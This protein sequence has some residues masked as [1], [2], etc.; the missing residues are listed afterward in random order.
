VRGSR[1]VTLLLGLL[2]AAA[3]LLL[4]T[5]FAGQPPLLRLDHGL[6]FSLGELRAH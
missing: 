3:L 5:T 2:L 4:L 1:R 6:W